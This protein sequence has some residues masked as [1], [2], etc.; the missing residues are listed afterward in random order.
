M[1]VMCVCVH[2]HTRV[3]AREGQRQRWLTSS[4]SLPYFFNNIS[5]WTW[6]SLIRVS[7][8]FCLGAARY[9]WSYSSDAQLFTWAC[10]F[11]M[12]SSCLHHKPFLNWPVSPAPCRSLTPTI[13]EQVRKHFAE[14]KPPELHTDPWDR[15]VISSGHGVQ[16]EGLLKH[17]AL[18]QWQHC[19]GFR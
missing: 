3:H 14:K 2:V 4:S 16:C 9:G 10:G 6:G 19:S 17:G 7:A 8:P 11:Q 12:W 5:H 15:L 1:C 18:W 13:N